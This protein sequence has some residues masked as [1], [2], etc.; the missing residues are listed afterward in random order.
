MPIVASFTPTSPSQAVRVPMSSENGRP[1]EKPNASITAA[2]RVD[3]A[4][5]SS[6]NPRGR[7]PAT[8]PSCRS[9]ES[10]DSCHALPSPRMNATAGVFCAGSAFDPAGASDRLVDDAGADHHPEYDDPRKREDR[11][12]QI[13][14]HIA[15]GV[16][17]GPGPGSG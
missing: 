10:L 16:D 3:S 4:A 9:P 12:Q 13:K 5:L 6:F 15:P 8:V 7:S 2:L 14:V 11:R 1:E 17:Q